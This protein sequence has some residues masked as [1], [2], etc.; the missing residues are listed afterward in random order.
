MSLAGTQA[1]TE[2]W[3][4]CKEW[5][6]RSV[7]ASTT[8]TTVSVQLKNNAGNNL[9]SAASIASATTTA[10]GVM[11]ADD[12][13]KLDGI[14][15]GAT[16]N[17]GTVTSV[18]IKGTSPIVSSSESAI[19]TSGTRT[20]S[21]ATSGPS[22]T[23]STSKGDTTAQTPG[24]GGTFKAL[25]ATVDK[26]GHT[27]ALAEHNV[28]IP[29]STASGTA[30]GL[31]SSSD[32]SKLSGIASGAEVNQ[33]AFGNV[34][35]GSSTIA[36]DSK[37]D[38]L[39]LAAGANV[40]LTADTSSDKVTIAATDTTY[41][42]A[43]TSADGLMSSSDFVKLSGIAD[44]AEPNV[45]A[46]WNAS[47][48]DAQILNKPSLG[49]ASSKTVGA[50]SGNLQENGAALSASKAV[51]TDANKKLVTSSYALGDACAKSV[52]TSISAGTSSTNLPTSKAV[53]DFVAGQVTGA[54]AFQGTVNSNTDISGLSS[55]TKGWY[56]V[57]ATAGNYVG[58]TCEV[59][60]MVFAIANKGASYSASD[61]TVVQNNIVEMTA[62]EVDA[63]CV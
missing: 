7:E 60:D 20:L 34:K 1:I 2:F 56:W 52:D 33:N 5:F 30:D 36:A 22:A 42:A 11:S 25:S 63:I 37:T 62:A 8:A 45:N 16:A 31:M 13:S 49:T 39:E 41:G 58:Q 29:S 12:K 57:V 54:T 28:T 59:G 50:A 43:T 61:F 47:S 35:V 51:V 27:T 26:Y 10:A 17:A 19:T 48:G 3:A 24:F 46:D 44:G 18:I 4:K 23:G 21:H 9:G 38:T 40:T 32:Y 15:P 14:A 53:S 6:G 55:Y